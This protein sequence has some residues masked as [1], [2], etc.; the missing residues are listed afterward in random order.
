MSLREILDTSIAVLLLKH[1]Y[2]RYG[3][4]EQRIIDIYHYSQ[5]YRL[6]NELWGK[7]KICFRYSFLGRTTEL[8]QVSPVILDNS[9]VV[10]YMIDFYKKW[11]D[12]IVNYLGTSSTVGLAKDTKKELYFSPVMIIS[13]I[14]VSAITVNVFLSIILQRQ[15]GLWGWL[16]RGLFLFTAVS[17]LFCQTDWSTVKESSVFLRKMRMD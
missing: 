2:Q 7:I 5:T 1:L 17:G 14:V 3:H 16:I 10:Q 15:I 12:K 6:L 4:I 11:K 8:K 9:Q 13:I